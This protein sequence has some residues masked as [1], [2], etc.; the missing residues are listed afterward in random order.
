MLIGDKG[1]IR[2]ILKKELKESFG[3]ELETPLR[4]NMEDSRDSGLVKLLSKVRKKIETVI[5]QLVERFNIQRVRTKEL[6]HFKA[7]VIRKLLAHTVCL[8]LNKLS[9]Q[10]QNLLSF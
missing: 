1:Y 7:R 4:K 10:F 9:L 2:P 8:K 5:S 3:I 6:W